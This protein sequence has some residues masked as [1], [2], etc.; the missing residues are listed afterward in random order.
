MSKTKSIF[1]VYVCKYGDEVVYVGE[2]A[3]GR[4]R[5]CNSGRSHVYELNELYFL[6]DKGLFEIDVKR[7]KT[8]E[9]A[10]KLEKEYINTLKPK[11]NKVFVSKDRSIK[12]TKF[13]SLIRLMTDAVNNSEIS[14]SRKNKVIKCIDQF[15]TFHTYDM[16]KEEGLLLRK[17]NEYRNLGL[18]NLGYAINGLNHGTMQPNSIP[19]TFKFVLEQ[20]CT[21]HFKKEYKIKFKQ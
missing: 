20:S 15:I 14:E 4:H 11:F 16:I 12:G 13:I 1:E 7:V 17:H 18:V 3:R 21:K 5:H 2:G 6:G 8:K 9:E 19:Y 10:K